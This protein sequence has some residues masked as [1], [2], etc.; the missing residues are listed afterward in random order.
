[1]ANPTLDAVLSGKEQLSEDIFE[2]FAKTLELPAGVC[3]ECEDIPASVRCVDC[4][5]IYCDVCFAALHRKGSRKTHQPTPY[6]SDI[7]P[8]PAAAAAATAAPEAG[9]PRVRSLMP[10]LS[11]ELDASDFPRFSPDWFV[12]RAK[13]IPVRLDLKERK[14][15]RLVLAALSAS[16]YTG[17]VDG[18]VLTKPRRM[19]AQLQNI[20]AVLSGLAIAYDRETAVEPVRERAFGSIR[21]FYCRLFEFARRHKIM[22]PEKMRSD[23]GKLVYL[24]QDATDPAIQELLGCYPIEPI[25]SVYKYLKEANAEA[26]LEDPLMRI[27]TAEIMPE[28][29]SR[30]Q[31]DSEIKTKERA[32]E[33]L[34]RNYSNPSIDRDKIKWCLYSITDNHSFLRSNRQ[35]I[36]DMLALLRKFF[37]PDSFEEGYSLAITSG[38]E[39]A[40]LTHDHERHFRF[41]E[42]SLTLWSEITDDMFRL[43]WLAESDLLDP[44]S[45]Y[46]LKDTGQ[47][48]QRVQQAPRV[49]V[50]MRKILHRIQKDTW[51]GSHVIHLGDNNVP[52]A[53]MFID[54]YTQISRILCPIVQTVR[55]IDTN[56]RHVRHGPYFTKAF[57]GAQR[58]QLDIL[59][60][61]F[62][63]AFD[64]SGAD[65]FFDAGS[66]IDG[67]LT[68]AWNWCSKLEQKPFLPVFRLA[69]FVG[70]DGDFQQ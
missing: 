23:Y 42:Q 30:P 45:R 70:F 11:A 33:K 47:G 10:Q 18:T 3:V 13:F 27:A 24:L 26:L 19:H 39:G 44:D 61:F 60:D 56:A 4:D 14:R 29:K 6:K 51:V 1:M 52:N 40:R 46:V 21:K 69:G 50:A 32:I 48:L 17:R 55:F 15:L 5:D 43:W 62:R 66:C 28:G 57:G 36:D 12:E 54:K 37:R 59:F 35:P 63:N 20:C 38:V 49:A 31:I 34:S 7:Q 8:A 64:G 41:V 22:N 68:S 67:R 16:D 58:L 25:C 2:R 53:L 9:S 65:N